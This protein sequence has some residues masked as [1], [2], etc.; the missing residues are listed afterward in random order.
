MNRFYS[1]FIIVYCRIE[2]KNRLTF[3]VETENI[4][5]KY[6]DKDFINLLVTHTNIVYFDKYYFF[7]K[8]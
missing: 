5:L 3:R 8:K 1:A 2:L 6:C 4:K 7:H